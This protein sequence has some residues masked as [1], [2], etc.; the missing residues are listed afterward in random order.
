MILDRAGAR[1]SSGEVQR[2]FIAAVSTVAEDQAPQPWYGDCIAGGL[3]QGAQ[4]SACHKIEGV[5]L[6]ISE[7]ADQ[8]GPAECTEVGGTH[9]DA[10]GRIQDIAGGESLDQIPTGIEDIHE[11]VARTGH[12]VVLGVI[13][14]RISDEKLPA[15][16][17]H[18]ERR[19]ARWN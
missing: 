10:P 7:V 9:G 19:K 8:Q 18:V 5:N 11:P 1:D 16:I 6:S 3:L 2:A 15:H 13:L 12:I 17:L 4:R 14:L